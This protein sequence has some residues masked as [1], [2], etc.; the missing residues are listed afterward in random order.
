[1][2]FFVWLLTV[3]NLWFGAHAAL[4]ALGILRHGKYGQATTIIFAIAFLGMGAYG[5]YTA[6]TGG[7]LRLAMWIG[8]GPWL[9]AVVVL[10]FTMILSNP[11]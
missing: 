5:A 9:I 8:L 1:M 4:N 10:F 7:N 11:Q 2:K 3:V 6:W